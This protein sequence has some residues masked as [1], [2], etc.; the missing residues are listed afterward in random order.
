MDV[1]PMRDGLARPT[2]TERIICALNEFYRKRWRCTTMAYADRYR[3]GHRTAQRDLT[4]MADWVPGF[5]RNEHGEWGLAYEYKPQPL[6][7]R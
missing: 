4:M 5:E 3:I 2:R 1:S 6:P 7:F